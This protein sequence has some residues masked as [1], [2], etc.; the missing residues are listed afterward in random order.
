MRIICGLTC[1]STRQLSATFTSTLKSSATT[2]ISCYFL[3]TFTD[4]KS[5]AAYKASR[6]PY[7]RHHQPRCGFASTF[8]RKPLLIV[9]SHTKYPNRSS[10][11]SLTDLSMTT[12]TPTV[13]RLVLVPIA[14]G[15]EEIETACITDTL[16]RFGAKVT[17]A[18]V[19]PNQDLVCTMSRGLKIVADCTIDDAV[20]MTDDWDLIV[21]PGGMPGAEHL[22]DCATLR[23]LLERHAIQNQKPYAAMCAAP[24][25]VLAS[26]NGDQSSLL[27]SARSKTPTITA[28]CYPAPAFRSQLLD[29][30]V[31][32][33]DESV[34][35]SGNLITSQ[36]PATALAFSLQL[37]EVLYGSEKRSEIAKAMLTT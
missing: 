3:A 27:S 35:V 20:G 17:V 18:S 36:G 24:A 15:S 5:V 22:R 29:S 1:S 30:G 25:V 33:S 31:N 32:V 11:I 34:V 23:T 19:K 6:D 10:F 8:H 13:E 37:G 26:S 28:T 14:D 4:T 9:S 2:L 16:T 12:T 7:Y 21:L